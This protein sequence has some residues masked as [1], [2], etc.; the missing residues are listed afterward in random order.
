MLAATTS[1]TEATAQTEV[2]GGRPARKKQRAAER[3]S[4][5]P[6]FVHFMETGLWQQDIEAL[7]T[8]TFAHRRHYPSLLSS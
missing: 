2:L 4:A 1:E 3:A 5:L 8:I 6:S 7:R